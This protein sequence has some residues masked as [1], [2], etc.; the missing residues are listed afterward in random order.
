MCFKIQPPSEMFD[1][2][3]MNLIAVTLFTV[4][5][6][7]GEFSVQEPIRSDALHVRFIYL[8]IFLPADEL[9]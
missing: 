4:R 1:L 7:F 9:S 5:S 3:K 2:S 8:F 6:Y